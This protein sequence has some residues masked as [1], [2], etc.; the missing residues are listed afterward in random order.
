MEIKLTTVLIVFLI[1]IFL[2]KGLTIFN[3]IKVNQNYPEAMGNDYFKVEQ[4]P[5]AKWFFIQFGLWWGTLLYS[6]VTLITLFIVYG[7]LSYFFSNRVALYVII[8]LYGFVVANNA[9]FA[10]KYSQV[11]S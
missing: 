11:I 3:I 9:Y 5:L 8:I 4:N 6:I 1:I 10:L 2:D 7:I